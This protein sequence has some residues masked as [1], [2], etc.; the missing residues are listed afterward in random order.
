MKKIYR[1]NRETLRYERVKVGRYL[2]LG[3]ILLALMVALSSFTQ[4]E[5]EVEVEYIEAEKK[6][7]LSISNE[8]TEEAFLKEVDKY[9]FRFPDVIIAQARLESANF[10]SAIFREGNN[11]FGMKEAKSRLTLAKGTHR[12]HAYYDSW[13]ESLQDRALYEASYTHKIKNKDNYIAYLDRLYAED[14]SYA[15]KLQKAIKR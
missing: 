3:V 12:N 7:E 9:S 2:L 5:A 11:I 10:T 1:Y 8:F 14:G 4:Q 6:I 13:Q 15:I